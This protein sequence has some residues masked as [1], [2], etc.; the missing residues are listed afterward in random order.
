[1]IGK[2][3]EAYNDGYKQEK[4]ETEWATDCQHS[5]FIVIA[6]LI[7]YAVFAFFNAINYTRTSILPAI[8]PAGS[9]DPKASHAASL[10]RKIQTWS[11]KNHGPAMAFVAYVEVIGVMGSLILGAIT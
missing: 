2:G 7:P 8:F 11:E 5:R 10:S 3:T 4:K 1:M 6:P 9:T